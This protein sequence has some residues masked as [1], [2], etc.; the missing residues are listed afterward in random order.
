[1]NDLFR[2]V[3]SISV[4]S[5]RTR[6]RSLRLLSFIEIIIDIVLFKLD[7]YGDLFIEK[8]GTRLYSSCAYSTIVV[9]YIDSIART[10]ECAARIKMSYVHFRYVLHI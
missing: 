8:R 2:L 4:S 7:Y 5:Y 10:N 6:T 1:M 3:L 9:Q